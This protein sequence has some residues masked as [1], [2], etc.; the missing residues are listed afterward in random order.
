VR[1]VRLS[2]WRG[3]CHRAFASNAFFEC[4]AN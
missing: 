1:C 2:P 4:N 3:R